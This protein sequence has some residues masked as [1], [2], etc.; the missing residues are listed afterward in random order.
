METTERF[1]TVVIGGGQAGLSAGYHLAKLARPFVILDGNQR[2]GDNWRRHYDSLRLYSPACADGLPGMAFPGNR[3]AYPTKDEMADFLS[4]Y[5]DRFEL[6]VR[7]SV[8]VNKITRQNG[9][10]AV[11]A[12]DHCFEA[13]DVVVATGT[14]GLPHTPIFADGIDRGI[15]QLHSSEYKNP[16][17][18]VP[19]DVLVV[20]AAHSGADIA[21]EVASAGHHTVLSGPD[22]GQLGFYSEARPAASVF[23]TVAP[24]VA[25]KVLT[26]KTPIGRKARPEVRSHG[27]PL[28]RVKRAH[29]A[30]AGVER[31][32]KKTLAVQDGLP[33]LAGGRPLDVANVIWATGFRHD[34]SWIDI[35]LVG[36]DGWPM[37]DRGVVTTAPGLYFV[38]L[39][40]QYSFGSMLVAGVGRDAEYVVK[41]LTNVAA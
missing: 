20:G 15:V 39:P 24:F 1:D 27:G 12:G 5:A 14:F 37:E 21:L 13:A 34:F 41:H 40:F 31:I 11:R 10:F 19:G 35:P 22:R 26:I 36:D 16:S 23:C 25:N 32:E 28:L 29:L 3:H 7:N 38:G 9:G 4:D 30:S 33:V 8:S 6:P 18:L 2:V 17:Q